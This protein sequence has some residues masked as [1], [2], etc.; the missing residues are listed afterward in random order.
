[1][2]LTT[3]LVFEYSPVDIA[4]E[5]HVLVCVFQFDIVTQPSFRMTDRSYTA[6]FDK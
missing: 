1:M 3:L 5:D 2:I 6:I 4:K